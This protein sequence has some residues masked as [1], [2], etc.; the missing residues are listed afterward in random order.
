MSYSKIVA[1]APTGQARYGPTYCPAVELLS[2]RVNVSPVW[3]YPCAQNSLHPVM[4]A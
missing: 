3:V 1:A 4:G 2:S